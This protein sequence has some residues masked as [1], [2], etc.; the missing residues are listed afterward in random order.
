MYLWPGLIL[1]VL[2]G[3]IAWRARALTLGGALA[4]AITG[5]LIFG[6]GGLPWAV[7]LLAFFI[8]SSGLSY[9]FRHKKAGLK[10]RYAKGN[11]RDI[12]QVVANGGVGVVMA[13]LAALWPDANA[14][15]LA[16]AGAMAA[17]NADTWATEL[18]VLGKAAPRLITTGRVV[19][20]GT[21]GGVTLWGYLAA[22]A[23]AGLIAVLTACLTPVEQFASGASAILFCVILAGLVGS[24]VDSILGAAVQAGYYCP[25]CQKET[26]QHPRHACGGETTWRRGWPWLDNDWVN[27]LATLAGAG[28]AIVLWTL[29]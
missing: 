12:A 10:D 2:I 1:G 24:T 14:W 25:I 26:E 16:F 4:A 27:L 21:S 19:S 3:F 13:I 11:Q 15:W 23:G 28:T 22:L 8:T 7:L 9:L 20:R 6:L 5:G 17:A 18:G 29:L